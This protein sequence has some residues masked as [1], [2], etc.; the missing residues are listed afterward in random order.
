MTV[1]HL[2]KLRAELERRHWV[3]VSENQ[4]LD[5]GK[6]HWNIAR[7]NGDSPLTLE[8]SPGLGGPVHDRTLES[9]EDAI[10]CD[11]VGHSEIESLY[12]AGKFGGK[13]QS[14]VVSFADAV[15]RLGS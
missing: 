2:A 7:P 14:D 8:F 13:F 3:I 9:I 6:L 10:A 1:S 4:H 12:F 5:G 11:V 15:N